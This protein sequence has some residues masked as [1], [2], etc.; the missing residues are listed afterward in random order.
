MKNNSRQLATYDV[1]MYWEDEKTERMQNRWVRRWKKLRGCKIGD[2]LS[3]FFLSL[4]LVWPK[5][6]VS[7]MMYD[8]PPPH[9]M[10]GCWLKR[11]LPL[12]SLPTVLQSTM[13]PFLGLGGSCLRRRY[14]CSLCLC[15]RHCVSNASVNGWLLFLSP[16]ACCVVRRSNL[17]ARAIVQSL[18]LLPQGKHPLLLT[19]ARRSPVALLPSINSFR[20]SRWWLVVAFSAH[21][22]AYRPHHQ[23]ENVSSFHPLGLM[24]TYLE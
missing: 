6:Q 23:A 13:Q 22:A 2:K 7:T 24:L 3:N 12:L 1:V 9:A 21:P 17:S 16:L 10:V 20:R 5:K 11:P 19:I 8:P 4:F 14:C 15:W 18:K